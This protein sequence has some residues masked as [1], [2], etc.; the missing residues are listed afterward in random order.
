MI[1]LTYPIEYTYGDIIRIRP[2]ADVHIGNAHCDINAF[3]SYLREADPKTYFIGIGD[4]YD[5]IIFSDP[6]YTRSSD[7]TEREDMLDEL[8]DIGEKELLPYKDRIICLGDGNHERR[9]SKK[10]G[11]NLIK[12]LAKRLSTSYIGYSSL[13]KLILSE[14]GSRGRTVI[15]RTHHGWGGGSRTQGADITKFSKDTKYWDADIFL[16]GHVHKKQTDRIPRIGLIGENMKSKPKLLAICGTF[17]K[18]YSK[19]P[20][21]TYSEE[22]GY[23][24][25]DVGGLTINIKPDATYFKM[26]VDT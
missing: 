25:I 14:K 22:A 18:T 23:P 19:G 10:Y 4:L 3:R 9:I 13:I 15:I 24:P 21:S 16:Y 17:L 1:V 11:T 12:R 26:W 20:E 8:I 7:G 5:A 6:R 2:I